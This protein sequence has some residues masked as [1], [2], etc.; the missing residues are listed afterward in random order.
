MTLTDER[1]SRVFE[2]SND[3][4]FIIDPERDAILDVNPRA[5]SMLGFSREELLALPMSAIHPQEMPQLQAFCNAV[6]ENEHGWTNE[7]TCLTKS[8]RFLPAEI[9]ASCITDADDRPAIIAMVRDISERKEAEEAQRE[10]A[11]LEERNRLA[12]EIHDSLA[13]GL[14]GIIWQLNAAERPITGGGEQALQ[15]LERIRDLARECLQE[16]RRSVW[17]LRHGPLEGVS[18]AEA[19]RRETAKVQGDGSIQTSFAISGEERVLPAGL[20]SA[21]LRICQESLANALRHSGASQ[22]TVTLTYDD[23]RVLLTTQDNGVGFDPERPMTS[24]SDKGGFGLISMRERARLL[25]GELTVQSAP[26]RGT[27]VEA[28]L[29]LR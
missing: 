28:S 26:G 23:S 22:V 12:R 10:L 19:L 17:D 4:I 20:E 8:G 13:H 6:F 2:Y 14:T 11:V 29:P 9:S 5:C 16:A 25:G 1:F 18:L 7:L 3:A 15:A 24:E 27:Q 21:L